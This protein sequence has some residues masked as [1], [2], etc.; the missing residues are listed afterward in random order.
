MCQGGAAATGR[1]R[2]MTPQHFVHLW[3]QSKLKERSGS[4]S[5]FIDVC[6]L[7]GHGTPAEMD[8]AGEFFTFEAGATKQTGYQGWA[9]V[10]K[11]GFFAWEYKGKHAD[12][13]AAYQQLLQYREALLNPPLLVVSDMERIVIH[14]NFT[15]TVKQTYTLELDDLLEPEK[16]DI[17]RAVFFD[18]ERLKA[19][20]TTE[21]VTAEA[22]AHFARL[23]ERFAYYRE[24][25]QQ[26]AHYLIRLFFC[27]FAEDIGLLPSGLF[28]R[29]L[30]QVRTHT[31]L[32]EQL[33]RLFKE[34]ATGGW[35][36]ADRIPFI[37]GGLF[38]DA[39]VLPMPDGGVEILLEVSRLDWSAIEPSIL[40][41]LFE[42]SLDPAKRAQLGAHY[43]SKEDILLIVEPVLMAPLRRRWE[44]VRDRAEELGRRGVREAVQATLE[45]FSDELAAV[46]VLDP[47]CGAPRGAV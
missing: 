12:L 28:T 8:P 7:V 42:R 31:A 36:G 39:S 2:S 45:A 11:K 26:T 10:W 47:A 40:G 19:Q 1:A 46:R 23:T 41:T 29:L 3:K 38:D 15:N 17:L 22:A 14:T 33:S 13:D 25:P 27:L 18:P 44:E 5:H 9:D 30:R 20:K 4:Q 24:D 35:F 32:D 43:T 34:M 21:H 6:R 37:N 16:R